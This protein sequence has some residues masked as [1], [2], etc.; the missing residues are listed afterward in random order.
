MAPLPRDELWPVV[1][2]Y[3]ALK[4]NGVEVQAYYHQGGHG[5]EP[6]HEQMN[7]WFTRYLY[8]IENGVEKDPRA[9]IVR[10]SWFSSYSTSAFARAVW[11]VAHQWIER[12]PR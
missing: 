4:A 5:G 2:A 3:E 12:K 10:D 8:G 7:R 6:P 11:Q 1:E 9:W